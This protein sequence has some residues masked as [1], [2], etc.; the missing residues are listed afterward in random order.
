MRPMLRQRT[1]TIRAELVPLFEE[2][3]HDDVIRWS[4]YYVQGRRIRSNKKFCVS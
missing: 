1:G 4:N 3:R 2:R